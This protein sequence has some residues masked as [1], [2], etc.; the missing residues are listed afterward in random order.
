MA[1][2]DKLGGWRLMRGDE[3][4]AE[5]AEAEP[6]APLSG[7]LTE[8]GGAVGAFHE[9]AA[10]LLENPN[11]AEAAARFQPYL[12]SWRQDPPMEPRPPVWV[13]RQLSVIEERLEAIAGR[14]EAL[15]RLAVLGERAWS[16]RPLD[17]WMRQLDHFDRRIAFVDR[18]TGADLDARLAELSTSIA[19][20]RESLEDLRGGPAYTVDDFD[21]AGQAVF[22][23]DDGWNVSY[24]G[25]GETPI[26]QRDYYD[27][28]EDAQG[29]GL[30]GASM[31]E[32]LRSEAP[33]VTVA[34]AK[35]FSDDGFD[36]G[37]F[38]LYEQALSDAAALDAE[39]DAG[40]GPNMAATVIGIGTAEA[41]TTPDDSDYYGVSGEFA[42]LAARDVAN[43][44][45][46]GDLRQVFG[47]GDGV[48]YP[49]ADPNA[50]AVSATTESGRAW[51]DSQRD[52]FLTDVFAWGRDRPV[53]NEAGVTEQ[54]SGGD[55]AA[56]AV[57][58]MAARLQQAA[59][60][61]LGDTL[62]DDELVAILQASGD[63]LAGG[64]DIEG[65]MP[66]GYAV[67]SG[68]AA[69][70]YFLMNADDFA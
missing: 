60:R 44:T 18:K 5:T 12:P 63:A 42:D 58:G 25:E 38:T 10:R 49:A 64:V 65:D 46:S 19:D 21:G 56:A 8:Q 52:P 3:A 43:L 48:A 36:G 23:I 30:I 55:L 20:L 45:S 66:A 16:D 28:D 68:D 54:L 15:H 37:D 39:W 67:A 9:I 24:Q 22:L 62:S 17:I 4:A 26:W 34:V 14:A 2:R 29:D 47:G 13:E 40:G 61:V 7:A 41:L 1:V 31:L 53:T 6:R 59:D 69:V 57:A 35:V 11:I 50:V 27:G 32:V 70:A 51:A 33:G